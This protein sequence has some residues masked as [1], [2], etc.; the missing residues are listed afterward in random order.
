M[1]PKKSFLSELKK[2]SKDEDYNN[3]DQKFG[4]MK[5]VV[6]ASPNQEG[7][8]AGV[9][10]ADKLLKKRQ[11][12]FGESQPKEESNEMS[13]SSELPENEVSESLE[14]SEEGMSE[15]KPQDLQQKWDMLA[16]LS[17]EDKL[18]TLEYL[19]ALLSME[20]KSEEP[21]QESSKEEFVFPG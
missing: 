10:L 5:K 2:K 19:Q 8:E 9:S 6:V 11:G 12:M 17:K 20:E 16:E 7:L 3:V 4:H 14:M 1:D 13:M 18:K 15:E 21:A